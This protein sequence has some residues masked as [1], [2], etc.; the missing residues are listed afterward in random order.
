MRF[1][2]IALATITLLSCVKGKRYQAPPIDSLY[3]A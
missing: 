1:L 2:I 3:Y